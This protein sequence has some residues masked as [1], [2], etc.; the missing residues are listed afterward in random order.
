MEIEAVD[1]SLAEDEQYEYIKEQVSTRQYC[2]ISFI[3]RTFGMGFPKAGRMFAKL[4]KDGIVATEGDS[5]GNE[6]LTYRTGEQQMGAIEQST[7]IPD[8]D[9]DA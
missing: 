8:Y 9:Q 1:K 4:Q 5:R 2:S 3:Q 7:F 6:V